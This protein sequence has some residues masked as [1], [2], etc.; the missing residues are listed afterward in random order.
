MGAGLLGAANPASGESKIRRPTSIG[1]QRC[2]M[3]EGQ[4]LGLCR[5]SL[6]GCLQPPATIDH[7]TF[8]DRPLAERMRLLADSPLARALGHDRSW[9]PPALPR[10]QVQRGLPGG[11]TTQVPRWSHE[12]TRYLGAQR[13]SPP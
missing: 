1:T 12:N 13:P 6:L 11:T 8:K 3:A 4:G 5:D 2:S 10:P 7:E 9:R